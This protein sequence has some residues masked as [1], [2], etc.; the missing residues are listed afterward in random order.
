[1]D[2]PPDEGPSP[3][4]GPRPRPTEHP[5]SLPDLPLGPTPQPM[6][7][8]PGGQATEAAGVGAAA[9]DEPARATGRRAPWP[10]N[11]YATQA[12]PL[13]PRPPQTT[14]PAPDGKA[15]PA[16]YTEPSLA[17]SALP[18]PPP[19]PAPWPMGQA[20]D[21]QVMTAAYVDA[22]AANER[23][24]TAAA[25]RP[26]WCCLKYCF[27]LEKPPQ[28]RYKTICS[29]PVCAP[30]DIEGN[31]YYPTCWRRWPYPPNSSYCPTPPPGAPVGPPPHV[32]AGNE[33]LPPPKIYSPEQ[34]TRPPAYARKGHD[35]FCRPV[36]TPPWVGRSS[37]VFI[38]IRGCHGR[39]ALTPPVWTTPAVGRDPGALLRHGRLRLG[40]QPG[41]R[42]HP[43][44][45]AAAGGPG[46]AQGGTEDHSDDA[47]APE[48]ACLL[49]PGAR[50]RARRL[51]RKRAGRKEPAAG[52]CRRTGRGQRPLG[53]P[54]PVRRRHASPTAAQG[55]G[56]S[57]RPERGGGPAEDHRGVHR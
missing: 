48:A 33:E 52:A 28:V 51:H 47:A 2:P 1:M 35:V 23:A 26:W 34:V 7:Q 41:G 11:P 57:R 31:G 8:A 56:Q 39:Q 30:C 27:T 21:G 6:G 4:T 18:A 19:N 54:L 38:A 37:P 9:T 20:P 12:V 42:R 43:G 25:C 22:A 53:F 5:P 16:S 14:G 24:C 50:R 49:P 44:Q 15:A 36:Y 29:K 55:A 13:P 46:P 32:G 45:P 3:E 10:L 40:H 17:T